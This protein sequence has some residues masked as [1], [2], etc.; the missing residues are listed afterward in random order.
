MVYTVDRGGLSMQVPQ[1]EVLATDW[2]LCVDG[3][4]RLGQE[5][6]F[7]LPP[8]L[9]VQARPTVPIP[10]F[11]RLVSGL[12]K[13][14]GGGVIAVAVYKSW[15]MA[16]DEVFDSVEF[17]A[18]FREELIAEHIKVYG[19]YCPECGYRVTRSEFTVD[20]ILALANGGLTS[21]RNARVICRSCNSSKGARNTL[22]DRLRGR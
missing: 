14:L 19:S 15:Q 1:T 10:T 4:W 21:R 7:G 3:Q 5:L 11:D 2:V 9:L 18:W 17:P 8:V 6:G 22:L 12:G 13:L 20:H 16:T